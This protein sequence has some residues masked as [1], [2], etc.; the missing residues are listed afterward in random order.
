MINSQ[1]YGQRS[2]PDI[3]KHTRRKTRTGINTSSLDTTKSGV[4]IRDEEEAMTALLYALRHDDGEAIPIDTGHYTG[5]DIPELKEL[6]IN[7][8]TNNI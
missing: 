6:S 4:T 1:V 5:C 3:I 2:G 7:E 8:L